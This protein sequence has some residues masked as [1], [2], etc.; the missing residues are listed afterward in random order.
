MGW[1]EGDKSFINIQ[2]LGIESHNQ[3][4]TD[5]KEVVRKFSAKMI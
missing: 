4:N 3:L 2:L 5:G 1:N